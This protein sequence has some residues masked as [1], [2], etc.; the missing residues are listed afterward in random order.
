MLQDLVDVGSCMLQEKDLMV[1]SLTIVTLLVSA[2][3]GAAVDTPLPAKSQVLVLRWTP[4]ICLP[5][6]VTIHAE[7][8]VLASGHMLQT[9][10]KM[11]VTCWHSKIPTGAGHIDLVRA[12]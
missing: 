8:I 5:L 1:D 2:Q 6:L 12:M 9:A 7:H 4:G 10:R 3:P 11:T